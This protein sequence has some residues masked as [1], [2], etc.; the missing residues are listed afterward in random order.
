MTLAVAK[1]LMDDFY[2]VA[3]FSIEKKGRDLLEDQIW[4]TFSNKADAIVTA[5][6]YANKSDTVWRKAQKYKF[7]L[8]NRLMEKYA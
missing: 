2:N 3:V 1:A 6:I 8:E 4:M 5:C 7:E